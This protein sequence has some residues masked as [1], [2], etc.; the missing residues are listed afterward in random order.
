MA[1]RFSSV[2][3]EAQ[4]LDFVVEEKVFTR[5]CSSK[6]MLVVNGSFPGPVIKVQKGDTVYVNVH[7][8]G[9][10]GLTMHCQR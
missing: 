9:T 3:P 1:M 7:N 8:R 5:L 4:Y 6:S 10:S 2:R